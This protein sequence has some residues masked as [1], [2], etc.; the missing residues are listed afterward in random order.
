MRPLFY[1]DIVVSPMTDLPAPLVLGG[2]VTALHQ[3]GEAGAY[4]LALPEMDGPRAGN[5]LRVFA[6]TVD[7][8]K[9]LAAVIRVSGMACD[10]NFAPCLPVP[11]TQEWARYA[12]FKIDPQSRVSRR[13]RRERDGK[14][15]A[16]PYSPDDLGAAEDRNAAKAKAH[17]FF[18]LSSLSTGKAF[19]LFVRRVTANPTQ[20]AASVNAY[21]FTSGAFSDNSDAAGHG[22]R[23]IRHTLALP[24]F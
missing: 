1:T 24:V 9:A 22:D 14:T 23:A 7:K 20:G 11:E 18:R 15:N 5:T 2:V 3:S 13:A 10:V 6:E 19:K 12:S 21:G 16:S 17:P 8:I 4:A